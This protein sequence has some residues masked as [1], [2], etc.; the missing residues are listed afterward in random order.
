[1]SCGLNVIS[2]DRGQFPRYA[3]SGGPAS[4]QRL[5]AVSSSLLG[6]DDGF[7]RCP[8]VIRLGLSFEPG[9]DPV[10]VLMGILAAEGFAGPEALRSKLAIPETRLI[11]RQVLVGAFRIPVRTGPPREVLV[12]A[13]LLG[14]CTSQIFDPGRPVLWTT[15][16]L[17]RAMELFD[18]RGFY[19]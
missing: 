4:R 19:A 12:Q 7:V 2:A 18:H 1:M 13:L 6:K 11:C 16:S 10:A 17:T 9:D 8:R 14:L 3:N 15:A 5:Q